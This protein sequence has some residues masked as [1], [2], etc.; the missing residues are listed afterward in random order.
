MPDAK[1]DDSAAERGA[2]VRSQ[3]AA[4]EVRV[5]GAPV[6]PQAGR[7]KRIILIAGAIAAVVLISVAV[8]VLTTS[9]G[10][11]GSPALTQAQLDD[12]AGSAGR[13]LDEQAPA[14]YSENLAVT[15]E[16]TAATHAISHAGSSPL[17]W[18]KGQEFELAALCMGRGRV[19]V[20]W[21]APGGV[22][23]KLPVVCSE[24]GMIAR[25]R[26]T[27]RADGWLIEFTLMPDDEAVGRSGIAV[28][29]VEFH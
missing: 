7:R 20:Q 9:C 25:T 14:S 21:Q 2:P 1:H 19:T 17:K 3:A 15:A 12:L 28:N 27:P 26:F 16:T 8:A 10:G 22:T 24:S 13:V 5:P 11:A 23:G 29:I 18:S 6:T 4:E